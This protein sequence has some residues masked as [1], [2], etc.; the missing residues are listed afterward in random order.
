[1]K[2]CCRCEEEDTAIAAP[3]LS[4][5]AKI[6][7]STSLR[8]VLNL[9][10]CA[11]IVSK[12]RGS[13]DKVI[14]ADLRLA[15]EYFLDEKRSVQWMEQQKGALISETETEEAAPKAAKA[16]PASS[17]RPASTNEDPE[18]MDTS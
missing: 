13:G 6:G 4:L 12:K 5:L 9:L 11:K 17:A 2:Y 1:M 15:Y 10:A 18:G 16:K 8:Y 3:A 14:A 7:M